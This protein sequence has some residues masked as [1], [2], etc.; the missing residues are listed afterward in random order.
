MFNSAGSPGICHG[1]DE[2]QE[3]GFWEMEICDQSVNESELIR[4]VDK[5]VRPVSLGFDF[6]SSC[7]GGGLENSD[8]GRPDC[9][10]PPSLGSLSAGTSSTRSIV[11]SAAS[12]GGI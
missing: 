6:L 11:S 7:L 10:D 12:R 9:D 8:R 4:R 1:A 2:H 3:A 5:N